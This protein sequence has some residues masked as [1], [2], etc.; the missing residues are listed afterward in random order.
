MGLDV[1]LQAIA[2]EKPNNA[3][4]VRLACRK[5]LITWAPPVREY[6]CEPRLRT[7]DDQLANCGNCLSGITLM[8]SIA[9]S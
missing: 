5:D 3:R 8:Q 6:G 2:E 9:G 4:M 1:Q 7:A